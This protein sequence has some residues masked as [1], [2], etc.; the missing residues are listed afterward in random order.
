MI[1][2]TAY[3]HLADRI[4]HGL[5]RRVVA[6]V[7]NGGTGTVFVGLAARLALAGRP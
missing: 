1:W 7:V 6:R 4:R 5:K 3:A 2:L